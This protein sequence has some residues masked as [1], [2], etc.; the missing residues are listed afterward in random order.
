MKRNKRTVKKNI[1]F[2]FVQFGLLTSLESF[3]NHCGF[4]SD[5]PKIEDGIFLII[6]E[7]EEEAK[8]L[9]KGMSR[10]DRSIVFFA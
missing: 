9:R 8:E 6:V 4:G 3:P 2:L 5:I 1:Q 10:K 7:A